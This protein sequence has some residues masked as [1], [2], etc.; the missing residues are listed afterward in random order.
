[1]FWFASFLFLE[2]ISRNESQMAAFISIRLTEEERKAKFYNRL[3][4]T[5]PK[6]R[7]GKVYSFEPASFIWR[8]S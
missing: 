4:F 8:D 2:I 1:M 3:V 6:T 5:V 7:T